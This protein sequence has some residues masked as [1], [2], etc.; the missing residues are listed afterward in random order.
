MDK[1]DVQMSEIE[2]IR[3][4]LRIYERWSKR[5]KISL[6]TVACLHHFSIGKRWLWEG[7]RW[8]K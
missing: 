4:L 1:P 6:A 7:E 3:V 8:L 5:Y 2:V